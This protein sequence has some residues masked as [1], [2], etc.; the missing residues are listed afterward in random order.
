[1]FIKEV[2]KSKWSFSIA[3]LNR[4]NIFRLYQRYFLFNLLPKV[5]VTLDIDHYMTLE[6]YHLPKGSNIESCK[7]I[8][9][10]LGWLV[11][12]CGIGFNWSY[13]DEYTRGDK[14]LI[15]LLKVI[16]NILYKINSNNTEKY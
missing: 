15:T 14:A 9:I 3:A 6:D 13:V 7:H 1:M 12:D 10:E 16:R 11:F 5:S 8:Y 2:I 4:A